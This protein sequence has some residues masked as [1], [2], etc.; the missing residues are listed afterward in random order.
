LGAKHDNSTRHWGKS[1]VDDLDRT[2]YC[3]R[4]SGLAATIRWDSARVRWF[5][6]WLC[7][8]PPPSLVQMCWRAG[9]P[10]RRIR[11]RQ[12]HTKSGKVLSGN[13]L[14][15]NR[16]KSYRVIVKCLIGKC[17][18]GLSWNVLSGNREKSHRVVGKSLIGLSGNVSSGSLSGDLIGLSWKVLSGSLSEDL[19]GL[20]WKVLSDLSAYLLKVKTGPY[21]G[22]LS[23]YSIGY[24]LLRYHNWYPPRI[25][26][27]ILSGGYLI[28][29]SYRISI[30]LI[31]I[32]VCIYR[33]ILSGSI[34]LLVSL[35]RG[36]DKGVMILVD[37]NIFVDAVGILHM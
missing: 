18:I 36:V 17:L 9:F 15:G 20:S 23:D 30:Y 21:R 26:S 31:Y 27:D 29:V 14:S 10:L 6:Y 8:Y 2:G 35:Y 11:L 5:V 22:I 12:K 28:G 25:S 19:I 16:E 37:N 33:S 3:K 1:F 32:W 7:Q 13:V 4:Q 34:S 24:P